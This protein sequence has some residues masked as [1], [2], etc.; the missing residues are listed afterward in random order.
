MRTSPIAKALAIVALVVSGAVVGERWWPRVTIIRAQTLPVNV[1]LS[2][3]AN[4]PADN[5]TSYLAQLDA[6]PVVTV[7]PP[8]L[9]TILVVKA[10]GSHTF[11]VSAVN[12]WGTSAPASLTVVVVP[13]GTPT[14]PRA[15]KAP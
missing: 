8:A 13:P 10:A 3:D 6:E 11:R 12:M 4:P 15:T 14:N 5:V 1:R 7:T 2:W 9:E